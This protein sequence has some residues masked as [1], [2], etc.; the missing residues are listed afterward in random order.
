MVLSRIITPRKDT[1]IWYAKLIVNLS[2]ALLILT[3]TRCNR[4]L[5]PLI[6]TNASLLMEMQN[7]RLIE[8]KRR[9]T[10]TLKGDQDLYKSA[11]RIS[12]KLLAPEINVLNSR[13]KKRI[14]IW[15]LGL[16]NV[17][18]PFSKEETRKK[19]LVNNTLWFE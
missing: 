14:F 15:N 16:I 6:F 10:Y 2:L 3:Y 18:R 1:W 12:R 13:H 7:R 4:I 17:Q 19:Y 8:I 11:R 9:S 5:H